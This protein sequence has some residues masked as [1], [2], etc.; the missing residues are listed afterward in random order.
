MVVRDLR[1]RS[2]LPINFAPD[3]QATLTT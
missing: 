1:T 3:K 2:A